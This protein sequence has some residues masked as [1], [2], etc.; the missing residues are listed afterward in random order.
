MKINKNNNEKFG[1]FSELSKKLF[2]NFTIFYVF[3][4]LLN[5]LSYDY[6]W[7]I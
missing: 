6:Q 7:K 4:Y 3:I 5:N 1:T 2:Q